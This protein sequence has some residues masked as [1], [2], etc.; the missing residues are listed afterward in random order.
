MHDVRSLD[1]PDAVAPLSSAGAGG[2][3]EAAQPRIDL[4]GSAELHRRLLPAAVGGLVTLTAVTLTI[5]FADAPGLRTWC[6][7]FLAVT[8]QAF[9]FLVLGV[10]ISGAVAAFVPDGALARVLPRRAVLAVPLA[11]VSGAL[12]PGCECSSVPVARRLI[13]S[14]A[15]PAAALT[16]LLAAPAINPV[17]IVATAVAF[18]NN[19]RMVLARFI[20]SLLAAT[21]VGLIWHRFGVPILKQ[22]D[23]TPGGDF[24]GGH[25]GGLRLHRL[26]D[27]AGH[28]FL[29]AG[30]FLVLG[31]ALAAT[32]NVVVPRSALDAVAGAGVLTVIALA[33]LAVALAV[34]SEADA[35]VAASLSQF[36]LTARLAFL[37]VGPMVDVKL[38]AMQTGTFGRR[39]TSRFAPVTFLTAVMTAI[40]VG[41]VVL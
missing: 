29:H 41:A 38:I 36:P 34:C 16:F 20:A 4:G 33:V 15:P 25:G 35:F 5:V 23:T 32:L 22:N 2:A 26:A 17:V 14:G 7:I 18:P 31:A 8:V 37:V 9:P 27:V 1:A 10:L 30:G 13:D 6:T 12:L 21:L 24:H 40:V 39:V 3:G 28:D 11:G 19:P